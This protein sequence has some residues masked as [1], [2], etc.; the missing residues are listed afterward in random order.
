MALA[1]RMDMLPMLQYSLQGTSWSFS[2]YFFNEP[3]C[4]VRISISSQAYLDVSQAQNPALSYGALGIV[5]LGFTQLSTIDAIVNHTGSA[6]GR[7]LLYNAFND[8]K[9]EPNYI[10]FSLQRSAQPDDDVQGTFSI[11]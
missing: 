1:G 9:A 3:Y 2:R 6:T 10:A 4:I 11:G 5:G 8:N 7:S